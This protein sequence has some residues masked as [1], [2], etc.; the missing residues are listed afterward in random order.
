MRRARSGSSSGRFAA[1]RSSSDDAVGPAPMSASST[2]TSVSRAR[3]S[4][5]QSEVIAKCGAVVVRSEHAAF[6]EEGDDVVD[7]AVDAVRRQVRHEDVAVG[8]VGLHV[9][10]DLRRDRRRA[11]DERRPRRHLDDELAHAQV[12]RLRDGSPLRRDRQWVLVVAHAASCD[13]DAALDVG[14]DVGKRTVGVVAGEVAAPELLDERDRALRAHLLSAD[15]RRELLGV[16]VGVADDGGRGRDDLQVLRAPAVLREPRLHV[17][18]EPLAVGEAGVA[19]E[20]HVGVLRRQLPTSVGVAGLDHHRVALRAAGDV[21]RALDRELVALVGE[22]AAVRVPEH[23]GHL[24]ELGRPLV[25]VV[26]RKE[27]GAAEVLAGEGIGRGHGVPR[28]TPVAQVIEGR[29][30]AGQLVGLV[31][32]RVE[33]GG[34]ADAVGDGGQARRAR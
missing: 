19:S 10:V 11:P 12:L 30:L 34:E 5:P 23:A 27:A 3:H 4:T 20:D 33:R 18:E 26:A 6:L 31:E 24:D 7:E 15:V 25:A 2:G 13:R 17:R 21:E 1:R 32:R 28:G 8:R 16:L 22:A 14:I 9:V 29:E